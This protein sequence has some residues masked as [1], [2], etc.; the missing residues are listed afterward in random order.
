MKGIPYF[1]YRS[2]LYKVYLVKESLNLSN[3]SIRT[4]TPIPKY[5]CHIRTNLKVKVGNPISTLRPT[6][7][8]QPIH[9]LL[10]KVYLNL[11]QLSHLG[12]ACSPLY[13]ACRPARCICSYVKNVPPLVMSHTQNLMEPK[14][15]VWISPPEPISWVELWRRKAS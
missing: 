11:G 12:L 4:K 10:P 3:L 13:D 15:T 7:L 14:D 2:V 5:F 1:I 9:F 8:S 6:L